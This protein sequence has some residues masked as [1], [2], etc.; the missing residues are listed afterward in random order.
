M[1]QA[2]VALG[3]QKII[4][5]VPLLGAVLAIAEAEGGQ[6]E[7]AL[8]TLDAALATSDR[9][10]HRAFDAEL[11][12]AR[13]ELLLRMDASNTAPAEEAFLAAIA[14]ARGQKARC[15]ALRAALSLAKLY[16]S[17]GRPIDAHDVLGPALEGFAP[18]PE[19]PEIGE[20]IEFVAA[21]KTTSAQL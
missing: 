12:R 14:I 16:Q 8:R 17:T 20:A 13:G 2:L 10:G 15:F 18:T 4:V 6:G 3:E 11:H 5:F 9:T 19:F 7:A 21:I 1:H